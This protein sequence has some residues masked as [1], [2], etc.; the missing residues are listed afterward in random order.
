[1]DRWDQ[2]EKEINDLAIDI[3]HRQEEQMKLIRQV[4]QQSQAKLEAVRT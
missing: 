3:K 4:H 2:A 1:M